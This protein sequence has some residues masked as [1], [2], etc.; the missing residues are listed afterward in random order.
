MTGGRDSTTRHRAGKRRALAIGGIALR[1]MGAILCAAGAGAGRVRHSA[2][3]HVR[4]LECQTPPKKLLSKSGLSATGLDD[5]G[6][7]G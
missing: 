7:S 3:H 5:L 2:M 1:M 6:K 4:S